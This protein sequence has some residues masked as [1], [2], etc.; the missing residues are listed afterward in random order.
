LALVYLRGFTN[1][2][3]TAQ[4]KQPPVPSK[5]A[6]LQTPSLGTTSTSAAILGSPAEPGSAD[7]TA[8]VEFTGNGSTDKGRLPNGLIFASDGD[9]Y[10]TTERGGAND[11]G[12]IFKMTTAGAL[13]TLIEFAGKAPANSSGMPRA[14][15]VETRDGDFYGTTSG[16]GVGP[17]GENHL[18]NGTVFRLSRSGVPHHI[19]AVLLRRSY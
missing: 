2:T 13:T 7:V 12:T 17:T 9:I 5:D 16:G 6:A 19:G 8:L 4:T 1:I 18:D 10:G 15:V 14:T 11:Y 3:V